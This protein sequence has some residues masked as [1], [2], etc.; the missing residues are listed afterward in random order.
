MRSALLLLAVGAPLAIF[1]G[2]SMAGHQEYLAEDNGQFTDVMDNWVNFSQVVNWCSYDS[3]YD[4]N[5]YNS[6]VVVIWESMLGGGSQFANSCSSP[7]VKINRYTTGAHCGGIPGCWKATNRWS[8]TQ[9]SYYETGGTAYLNDQDYNFTFY[10]VLAVANHEFGH[11]VG[12]GERY[13]AGGAGCVNGETT[14]MGATAVSGT[15]VTGGGCGTNT[16]WT[17]DS[18]R[19]QTLY[20]LSPADSTSIVNTLPDRVTWQWR[21]VNWSEDYYEHHYYYWNGSSWQWVRADKHYASVGPGRPSNPQYLQR[22]FIHP[23]GWPAG[24]YTSCIVTHSMISGNQ[25]WVC[26]PNAV[27]LQ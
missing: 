19:T 9:Q 1:T 22:T 14:I 26:T 12:L 4:Q 13:H 7:K 25:H 20:S 17:I 10:G 3:Q 8:Q 5:W 15:T 6:N 21:D 2:I 16:P 27:I 18:V 24:I 23:Q 11:G